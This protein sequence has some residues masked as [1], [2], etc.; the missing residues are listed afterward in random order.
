MVDPACPLARRSADGWRG[1]L[2]RRA[3]RGFGP[4]RALACISGGAASA[5]ASSTALRRVRRAAPARRRALL[6]ALAVD[7][8]GELADGQRPR[9]ERRGAVADRLAADRRAVDL[10]QVARRPVV[11]DAQRDRVEA[12][13]QVAEALGMPAVDCERCRTARPAADAAGEVVAHE[14]GRRR[15]RA[16]SRPRSASG[17]SSRAARRAARP[18]GSARARAAAHPPRSRCAA[19]RRLVEARRA[20]GRSVQRR[21][22]VPLRPADVVLLARRGRSLRRAPDARSARFPTRARSGPRAMRARAGRSRSRSRRR[23][24]SAS[25]D[26]DQRAQAAARSRG[27]PPAPK[28]APP[29]SARSKPDHGCAGGELLLQPV[30]AAQPPAEVVDHVHERRLA[31]AR[32][33]RAAVLERAVVAEDDV[34][35]PPARARAGSRRS[36][37]IARRTR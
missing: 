4:R 31:R 18:R 8:H 37:S 9:V 15:R 20:P 21:A 2:E 23:R 35:A 34:R 30:E 13:E 16:G 14:D 33:D 10:G 26:A 27:S 7:V 3:S 24:G 5:R 25:G 1:R 22:Q 28:Y 17:C 29:P 32:H 19:A 36:S 6:E 11:A 12:E